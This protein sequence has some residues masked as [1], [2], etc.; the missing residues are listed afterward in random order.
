MNLRNLPIRNRLLAGFSVLGALLLLLSLMSQTAMK[1]LRQNTVLLES[2]I[3]P[4]LV[5]LGELNL[6]VTRMRVFT[7]RMF[8]AENAAER[9]AQLSKINE[10]KV[11]L[12]QEMTRYAALI[13]LDGERQVFDET[14]RNFQQYLQGQAQVVSLLQQ[15]DNA[16]AVDMQDHQMAPLADQ[17]TKGLQR[18]M[19][20]NSDFAKEE[21]KTSQAA[22]E[23]QRWQSILLVVVALLLAAMLAIMLTN[24]ITR[25]LRTAVLS[26]NRIANNDLTESMSIDGK[27][28]VAQLAEALAQ[29]QQNLRKTLH[30]IA[31]SSNQLA[32]AAE[33]LN[34]VTDH[35]ARGVQLQNDEIQQAATAVTEMSS[36]VDEVAKTAQ[37]TSEASADSARSAAVGRQQVQQTIASIEQMN[38]DVAQSVEV[39]QQLA[40]QAQDIGKVL[41]VIRAIAEQTNLLALNAAIEA[42]RAGEAGRGFA[43]VADEVRAL[44]GRTQV[45]TREIEQMINQIRQGTG[46]AVQV[47]A[48]SAERA[49]SA[50]EVAQGAGHALETINSQI[51]LINDSNMVIASAAEEQSKVAREVDRNIVNI[52]DLASQSAASA[53]QT[54]AAAQ[55][56]SRL[57][58]ELNDLVNHFKT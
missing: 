4:T 2:N 24:S 13:A 53:A 55:E 23:Q 35:N 46:T 16:G 40:V 10:L 26:A 9:E 58:V 28:E 36:A 47:M 43:V 57:A 5:V 48:Q 17:I 49:R 54:T 18:L 41:D 14:Q 15:G 44:A 52:S 22:F 27:D 39:V 12:E 51:A 37:T 45:S 19:A 25:P 32:S 34:S 30:L 33:E 11:Q 29:M 8:L 21:A 3:V 38:S 20:I 42:A 6:N 7:L 50:A 1:Q 56:L 31:N